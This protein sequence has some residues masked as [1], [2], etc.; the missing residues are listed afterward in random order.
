[1]DE[2]CSDIVLVF[3]AFDRGEFGVIIQDC[4]H[5]PLVV[6]ACY[7]AGTSKIRVEK[8]EDSCRGGVEA[9]WG[10]SALGIRNDSWLTESIG[11]LP[12]V[13]D[14]SFGQGET[15]DHFFADHESHVVQ[16]KVSHPCVPYFS[17]SS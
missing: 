16:T 6:V 15:V 11:A 13:V 1:M 10:G 17:S 4:E 5:I 3:E 12:S 2:S 9:G 7:N 14:L 8:L